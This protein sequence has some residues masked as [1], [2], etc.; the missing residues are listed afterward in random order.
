MK[1]DVET[2]KKYLRSFVDRRGDVNL[3]NRLDESNVSDVKIHQP[4]V[5]L[6]KHIS[7]RGSVV[8]PLGFM[9]ATGLAVLTCL[10]FD[11]GS[12]VLS[13]DENIEEALDLPVLVTIP[14]V[15]NRRALVR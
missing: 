13:R 10:I 3:M 7:P 2:E 6:V 9:F 1:R 12:K 11:G 14:R 15:S 5:L 8:L 4:G